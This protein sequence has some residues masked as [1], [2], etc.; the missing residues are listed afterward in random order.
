M[1]DIEAP[2]RTVKVIDTSLRDGH[3]DL[4]SRLDVPS[5]LYLIE[6]LDQ[7]GV[8]VI[9]AGWPDSNPNDGILFQ[10]AKALTLRHAT[11]AAFGRTSKAG[12]VDPYKDDVIQALLHADTELVTLVGKADPLHVTNALRTTLDENLRMI[13]RSVTALKHEGRRVSFDAE[14]FFDGYKRNPRYALK[15]LET[16]INYGAEVGTLCD[17]N[18]GSH[19]R[20]VRRVTRTVSRRFPNI[21]VGIHV[22]NDRGFA[23]T[24]TLEAVEAGATQVQGVVNGNGERTGNVDIIGVVANLDHDYNIGTNVALTK[25]PLISRQVSDASGIPVPDNQP[26]SGRLS[27]T[28][29]A[30]LH[31][32]GTRRGESLYRWTNPAKFGRKN[33]IGFSDQGGGANVLAWAEIFGIPM[34][35][36]DP[37]Y[38]EMVTEMKE[39]GVFGEAQIYLL[40]NKVKLKK[41]LPFTVPERIVVTVIREGRK[42]VQAHLTVEVNGQNRKV[43]EEGTGPVDAFYK[44]LLKGLPEY[45]AE[46]KNVRIENYEV[47]KT[48]KPGSEVEVEV[49]THLSSNGDS[50]ESRVR[51]ANIEEAS[52]NSVIDALQYYLL[53]LC[54]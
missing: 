14:H 28:D 18:G 44:A 50:L 54:H 24:S 1:R 32:S 16:A 2:R 41:P 5:K 22:H 35:A 46:F 6:A 52:Q 37:E 33:E 19:Y 8:D 4:R 9:E 15:V 36:D 31:A 11:L 10:E 53:Y 30:G 13:E 29:N 21:E 47:P 49:R 27:W 40:F 42:S 45:H 23:L 25:I 3:Q 7:W 48:E 39:G 20:F 34:T 38:H 43:N 26:I 17:T 12:V 51:S